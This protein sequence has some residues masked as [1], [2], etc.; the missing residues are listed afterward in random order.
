MLRHVLLFWGG[1]VCDT[2]GTM[3]M[4]NIAQQ[5]SAGGFGIHAVTGLLAIVLMLV[6]AVRAVFYVTLPQ[7][8]PVAFVQ[9]F[10]CRAPSLFSPI[11]IE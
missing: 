4:S 1:L 10:H 6:H 9:V 5:S 7:P 8:F 3:I 2:T 11:I